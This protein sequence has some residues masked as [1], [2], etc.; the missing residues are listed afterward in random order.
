MKI[1]LDECVDRRLGKDLVGHVVTTVP[2][3]GWANYQNGDLL[4]VA[5]AQFDAFVTVDT[6]I[7]YQQNLRRFDIAV[8]LLRARTTRLRDLR[9]LVPALLTAL[10]TAPKGEL[11]QISDLP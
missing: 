6:N 7:R 2:K 4:R 3:A 5:Q 8:V 1:L 11:T 9:N 10:P